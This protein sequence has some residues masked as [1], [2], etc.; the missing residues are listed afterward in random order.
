MTTQNAMPLWPSKHAMAISAH[1]R[2]LCK[3]LSSHCIGS[4]AA[5]LR[6]TTTH[7]T[8]FKTPISRPGP[9]SSATMSEGHSLHGSAQSLSTNVEILVD[10]MPCEP[11]CGCS[12]RFFCLPRS[13]PQRSPRRTIDC[14]A[15]MRRLPPCRHS[16]RNHCSLQRSAAFLKKMQPRNSTPLLRRLKCACGGRDRNSN[17]NF[18]LKCRRSAAKAIPVR[19]ELSNACHSLSRLNPSPA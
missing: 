3:T 2:S 15:S 10:E 16:I 11:D 4:F 18:L 8:S 9:L 7:M 5:M 6:V 12:F 13:R 14:S 1:S 17:R 19:K